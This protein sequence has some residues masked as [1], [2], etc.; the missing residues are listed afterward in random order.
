MPKI[1]DEELTLIQVRFYKK[2]IDMLKRLYGGD[3]GVNKAIRQ[4]IRTFVTQAEARA[5]AIIDE[6]EGHP[7][8]PSPS[9]AIGQ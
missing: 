9:Q 2:D 5:N 8:P 7:I 6:A 4:I 1:T 3:F